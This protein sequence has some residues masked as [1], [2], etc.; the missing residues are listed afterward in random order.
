MPNIEKIIKTHTSKILNTRS[1]TPDRCNCREPADC[2]LA[3]NC[4]VKNVVYQATLTTTN[5]EE[6]TYTGLTATTFKTRYGSHK[7]SFAHR[8]KGK[9]TALA[10]KIW[11]LKDKNREYTLN[12][13]I[14]KRAHPYT[15]ATKKC[16]L[17][18][19]EKFHIIT[20]NRDT[21]LNQRSELAGECPRKTGLLSNYG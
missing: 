19:W 21:R 8:D 18:Q 5:G 16:S 1:K 20:A 6:K 7:E 10:K 3:G 14:L 9:R 4:T 15:P 11:E 17:C 13:K 2:P 12:W